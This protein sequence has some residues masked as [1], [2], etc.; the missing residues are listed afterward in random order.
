MSSYEH[1]VK[2]NDPSAF[3]YELNDAYTLAK[4]YVIHHSCLK[5]ETKLHDDKIK[6]KNKEKHQQKILVH[7]QM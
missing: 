2:A 3:H 6:S 7:F 4:N 1:F 5:Y